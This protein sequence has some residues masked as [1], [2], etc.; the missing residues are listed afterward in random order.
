MGTTKDLTHLIE[1]DR[2]AFRQ[3]A[4][5]ALRHFSPED[6]ELAASL[7]TEHVLAA[8][9]LKH[10]FEQ[11]EPLYRDLDDQAHD[12]KFV[13]TL[14]RRFGF[15][16]TAAESA[17]A[18]LIQDR[19][20][21]LLDE[22]LDNLY[23]RDLDA[24]YQRGY[25]E[26][27]LA[28]KP[29]DLERFS[30]TYGDFLTMLHA[31]EEHNITLI[32]PHGSWLERQRAAL[33]INRERN[34]DIEDETIRLDEID[35]QLTRLVTPETSPT[36]YIIH[37]DWDYAKVLELYE[38]Y[39]KKVLALS[40]PQHK[41]PAKRL[42]LFEQIT[43]DFRDHEAERLAEKTHATTLA[44]MKHVS[45]EVYA[46]LLEIFDLPNRQRQSLLQDVERYNRLN[47][48][49]DLIQLVQA[50]RQRFLQAE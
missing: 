44:D 11:L 34:R 36:A 46:H 48:E 28:Q 6:R 21:Q 8:D 38:K 16:E 22:V 35:T 32:D 37:N 10:W 25:A 4:T 15:S 1:T 12:K 13:A 40:E 14:K 39:H 23:H 31:A 5:E 7:E 18:T 19:K 45:E 43:A 17:I 29:A 30:E 41:N 27:F 42:K 50:N 20:D 47:Q 26:D 49:R 9:V 24:E 3:R 33:A 2:E